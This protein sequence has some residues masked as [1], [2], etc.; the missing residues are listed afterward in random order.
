MK[1]GL[2]TQRNDLRTMTNEEIVAFATRS[3]KLTELEIELT[4]RLESFI[5]IFGDYLFPGD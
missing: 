3:D 5:E 4:L 1:D 2:G